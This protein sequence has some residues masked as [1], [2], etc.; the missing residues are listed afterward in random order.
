[1]IALLALI[2]LSFVITKW[3][4]DRFQS[5]RRVLCPAAQL[6]HG[7]GQR[8]HNKTSR[9]YELDD[10]VTGGAT[11]GNSQLAETDLPS[12]SI[13]H[14]RRLFPCLLLLDG[15]RNALRSE[16]FST[17]PIPQTPEQRA[18][19]VSGTG[20]G[21]EATPERLAVIQCDSLD[22]LSQEDIHE[23]SGGLELSANLF[24][25]DSGSRSKRISSAI[26]AVN[27]MIQQNR[28][29]FVV[30]EPSCLAET[31]GVISLLQIATGY[32]HNDSLS[33]MDD[34]QVVQHSGHSPST[35]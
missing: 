26:S 5:T 35:R 6:H 12:T 24:D 34:S 32:H 3:I 22:M 17:V 7:S 10:G 2:L 11:A 27:A 23:D 29:P 25:E 15:H 4:K 14:S 16:I 1:M 9:R 8:V 28:S 30:D 21:V 18:S 13:G 19:I 31:A 20:Q 33:R